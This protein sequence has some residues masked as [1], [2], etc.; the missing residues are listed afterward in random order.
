MKHDVTPQSLRER[1]MQ[2]TN[3]PFQIYYKLTQ[4]A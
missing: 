1:L 3:I 4:S 2:V